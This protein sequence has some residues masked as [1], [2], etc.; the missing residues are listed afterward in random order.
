[1]FFSNQNHTHTHRTLC[2]TNYPGFAP[3]AQTS[4]IN[5]IQWR[6]PTSENYK[7]T[8]M[9]ICICIIK[10]CMH[11][12]KH[13]KWK[14]QKKNPPTICTQQWFSQWFRRDQGWS[15]Q[16][17]G[18]WSFFTQLLR[19]HPKR[20]KGWNLKRVKEFWPPTGLHIKRDRR[21]K[22]GIFFIFILS[23]YYKV[24]KK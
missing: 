4:S 5:P 12:N 3:Q 1:M 11:E 20:H 21:V 16:K 8:H 24:I 10:Q 7:F 17:A 2:I 14:S 22:V 15:N 18:P 13:E 19:T 9:Y 23:N 6:I